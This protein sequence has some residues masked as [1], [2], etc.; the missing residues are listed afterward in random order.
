M[1]YRIDHLENLRADVFDQIALPML[2]IRGDVEDFDHEPGGRI[3]MGEEGDVV[4]LP[5]DAT[6]LQADFQIQTIENKME[7]LAGAPR[8]AM[9]IRTPGEKTAF[10]V[11]SL[12]NAANRI[13]THKIAKFERELIEPVLNA[14]LE[15]GRRNM[16][17][18]DTMRVWNDQVG[19]EM[20]KEVKRDDILANGRIYPIGARHYQE[21]SLRVQNLNNIMQIRAMDPTV[22]VHLSSEKIAQMLS[23]EIGEPELFTKNVLVAEQAET[24]KASLDAEADIQEDLEIK[25]EEGL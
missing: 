11:D 23:H 12:Q 7:E 19:V 3:Y 16:R 21:R 8:S 14:M 10:E 4:P 6:A 13:F 22:G 20:F 1:Q 2:K 18:S 17:E 9:G 15:S 24:Q 25:A 5:P